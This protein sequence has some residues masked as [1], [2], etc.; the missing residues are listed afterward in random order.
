MKK[1][2]LL[3]MLFG[4]TTMTFLSSCGD[5]TNAGE[6]APLLTVTP[7]E[8]GNVV[9]GTVVTVEVSA[10]QNPTSKKDLKTLTVATPGT[11]TTITINAPTYSVTFNVTAPQE[12]QSD[13]YTFTL[14]DKAD[15]STTKSFTLTGTSSSTG[16]N[17]G[18][19]ISGA[20]FHIGGTEKGAYDLVAETQLAASANDANKDM[21][22]S[23]IAGDPFS[24][25]WKTGTGNGTRYVKANSFDYANGTVEDATTYYNSGANILSQAQNPQAGDIFIAKLRGGNDYA[26]I[27]VVSIDPNDNTCGCGNKGKITFSFKKSN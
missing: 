25:S 10:G 20:F 12:G 6:D 15:V 7:S 24:G 22:N 26:L 2:S 23:D 5:S 8:S 21:L 11:D 3:F 17:F 27:K 19:E 16:T 9:E 13:T 14:T 4:I 1:L 18:A